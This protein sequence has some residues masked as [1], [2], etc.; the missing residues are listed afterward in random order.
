MIYSGTPLTSSSNTLSKAPQHLTGAH[1]L[2]CQNNSTW[3]HLDFF[4]LV[5]AK[6]FQKKSRSNWVDEGSLISLEQIIVPLGVAR[7]LRWQ[8]NA[9]NMF[10]GVELFIHWLAAWKH[11]DSPVCRECVII[12]N[13]HSANIQIGAQN[14][15]PWPRGCAAQLSGTAVG[16]PLKTPKLNQLCM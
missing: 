16:D 3:V 14:C 10:L 5:S 7:W 1:S 13:D 15:I 11:T 12:S 2:D 9:T 6:I 8:S 4:L